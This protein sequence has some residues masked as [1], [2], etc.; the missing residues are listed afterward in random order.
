MQEWTYGVNGGLITAALL[1]SMLAA[2]ELGQ[3]LRVQV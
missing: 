1:V 3:H 2:I